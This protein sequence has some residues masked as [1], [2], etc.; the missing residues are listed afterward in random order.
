MYLVF[1]AMPDNNKYGIKSHNEPSSL[2]Y[3]KERASSSAIYR[4]VSMAQIDKRM[5][6]VRKNRQVAGNEQ[7]KPISTN[8]LISQL[9]R[10]KW[11]PSPR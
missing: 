5:S 10:S 11:I 2:I 8:I 3:S 9:F 6:S 7:V 4:L 1:S